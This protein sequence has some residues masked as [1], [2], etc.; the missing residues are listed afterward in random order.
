MLEKNITNYQCLVEKH[1]FIGRQLLT[2]S[3]DYVLGSL[4]FT[5]NVNSLTRT[6]QNN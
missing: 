2:V 4:A 3:T 6:A 5:Q 1:L